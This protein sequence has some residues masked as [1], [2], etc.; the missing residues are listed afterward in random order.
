MEFVAGIQSSVN[1]FGCSVGRLSSPIWE[2]MEKSCIKGGCGENHQ[3]QWL[4]GTR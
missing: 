1:V 4:P 3:T 2:N